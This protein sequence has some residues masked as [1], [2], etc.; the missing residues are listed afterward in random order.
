[1]LNVDDIVKLL[2]AGSIAFAIVIISFQLMRLIG[3]LAS[4]VQ[5]MRRAVQNLGKASDMAL[6]DYAKVRRILDSLTSTVTNFRSTILEPL[7]VLRGYMGR[8]NKAGAGAEN[9]APASE[10]IDE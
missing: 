5:D 1:M 3:G 6:E 7:S 8:S 2:L 9:D 4:V 10:T